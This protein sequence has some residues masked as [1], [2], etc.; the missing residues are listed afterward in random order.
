MTGKTVM[1]NSSNINWLRFSSG[2]FFAYFNDEISYSFEEMRSAEQGRLKLA[3]LINLTAGVLVFRFLYLQRS[4]QI[5]A[6]FSAFDIHTIRLTKMIIF[7]TTI[8][9]AS[10]NMTKLRALQWDGTG[11]NDTITAAIAKNGVTNLD[12]R[13]RIHNWGKNLTTPDENLMGMVYRHHKSPGD[14]QCLHS[15]FHRKQKWNSLNVKPWRTGGP[16]GKWR[17]CNY[18]SKT[19]K[20]LWYSG[21]NS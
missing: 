2:V 3:I 20:L 12:M 1:Q 19:F 16:R 11:S 21:S 17:S 9:N 13:N 18:L 5:G 8:Q 15:L 7:P 10:P 6:E 4:H 14:L